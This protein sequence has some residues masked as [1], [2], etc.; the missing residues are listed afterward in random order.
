MGSVDRH[1][2]ILSERR[3]PFSGQ[4]A[5]RSPPRPAPPTCGSPNDHGQ[6]F[7]LLVS[8]RASSLI[9]SAIG[10]SDN[11]ADWAKFIIYRISIATFA[12]ANGV[13]KVIRAYIPP[14]LEEIRL[15]QAATDPDREH[16]IS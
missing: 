7:Q 16:K 3:W 12:C 6:T 9:P 1:I 5:P 4:I 14:P 8:F 13:G 2:K 11:S 10:D 15:T